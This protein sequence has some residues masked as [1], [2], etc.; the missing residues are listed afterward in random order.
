MQGAPERQERKARTTPQQHKGESHK[1]KAISV[2]DKLQVTSGRGNPAPGRKR[3]EAQHMLTDQEFALIAALQKAKQHNQENED[4]GEDTVVDLA[5][6]EKGLETGVG[7]GAEQDSLE[8][9]ATGE[10]RS[11]HSPLLSPSSREL[12]DGLTDLDSTIATDGVITPEPKRLGQAWETLDGVEEEPEEMLS[13]GDGDE[14]SVG[15]HDSSGD[16]G[17][18]EESGLNPEA[19][20]V[21]TLEEQSVGAGATKSPPLSLLGDLKEENLKLRAMLGG[22]GKNKKSMRT[23]EGTLR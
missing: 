14:G 2:H 16:R 4:E 17:R 18:S 9:N 13:G 5:Q 8:V 22:N 21:N 20:S 1:E 19:T 6:D 12:L 15:E 11:S 3:L 10:A 7:H 23:Q